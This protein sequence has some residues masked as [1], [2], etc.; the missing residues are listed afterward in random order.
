MTATSSTTTAEEARIAP[1]PFA[2]VDP[3]EIRQLSEEI[4]RLK[5]EKDAVILAHNYQ[6][7]EIQ[8]IA[9][10]LGDSLGLSL[11]AQQAEQQT[12]V[13]CGVLFMAESAK[14]LNPG[15]RVLI[16]SLAAGC[17]LSDSVA[18]GDRLSQGRFFGL[19]MDVIGIRGGMP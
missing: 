13:F 2:H 1:E 6:V 15:K 19:S 18:E 10:H 11:V 17:S 3:E 8:E 12:I 14:I 7:P 16:P 5:V 9:D 4:A